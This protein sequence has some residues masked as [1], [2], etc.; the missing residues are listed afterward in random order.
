VGTSQLL[1]KK[2]ENITE[3]RS[4]R[5]KLGVPSRRLLTNCQRKREKVAFFH[6]T[7]IQMYTKRPSV[8]KTNSHFYSVDGVRNNRN[9]SLGKRIPIDN[10]GRWIIRLIVCKFRGF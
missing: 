4:G 8:N 6:N 9:S 7:K 5:N 10:R 3:K 1:G 2:L